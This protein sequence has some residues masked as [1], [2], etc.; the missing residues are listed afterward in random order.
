MSPAGLLRGLTAA[1]EG[2]AA[3]LTRH[4]QQQQQAPHNNQQQQHQQQQH[5]DQ[6]LAQ[7]V[8][9][10]TACSL[11]DAWTGFLNSWACS[12]RVPA[13]ELAPATA[14]SC[15]LAVA[16]FQFMPGNPAAAA[17]AAACNVQSSSS[18]SA[19]NGTSSSKGSSRGSSSSGSSGSSSYW[20]STLK[21]PSLSLCSTVVTL[22]EVLSEQVINSWGAAKTSTGRWVQTGRVKNL[23]NTQNVS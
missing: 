16:S 4:H 10:A 18:S 20:R 11:L 13:Q 5:T 3:V 19:S 14:A 7:L 21:N 23:I 12:K 15:K 22:A 8:S 1:C 2:L 6:V 9:P 17:A